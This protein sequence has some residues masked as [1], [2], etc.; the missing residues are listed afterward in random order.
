MAS[1]PVN[2]QPFRLLHLP[3]ELRSLV[4]ENIG[5]T[6]RGILCSTGFLDGHVKWPLHPRSERH[7]SNFVCIRPRNPVEMLMTCRLINKEARP[8]FK[9]RL[10]TQPIRYLI[11]FMSEPVLDLY[12]DRFL[13]GDFL[14][15]HILEKSLPSKRIVELT[16]NDRTDV[17]N[18]SRLDDALREIALINT[19]DYPQLVV[20]Y[21]YPLTGVRRP[22]CELKTDPNKLWDAMGYSIHWPDNCFCKNQTIFKALEG[23]PFEDHLRFLNRC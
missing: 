19:Y 17:P 12:L 7:R 6:V 4:Y 2:Q 13:D 16:L 3:A 18:L 5:I 14:G 10:E 15:H 23:A 22:C 20:T 1:G 8:N 11:D 9:R 21:K